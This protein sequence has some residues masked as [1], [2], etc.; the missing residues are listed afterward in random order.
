MSLVMTHWYVVT[1]ILCG[2]QC[3]EVRVLVHRSKVCLLSPL[4]HELL[5]SEGRAKERGLNVSKNTVLSLI[6]LNPRYARNFGLKWM[7]LKDIPKIPVNL[8]LNL[9]L[10][11]QQ[12]KEDKD[13]CYNSPLVTY[14]HVWSRSVYLAAHCSDMEG[15]ASRRVAQWAR[16]G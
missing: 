15:S 11:R 14:S 13:R 3:D 4:G 2:G 16:P 6:P 9:L 1:T 8:F 10:Q 12:S 5:D 7:N